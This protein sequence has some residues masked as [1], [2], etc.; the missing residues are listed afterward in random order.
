MSGQDHL[1]A[2]GR[3]PSPGL[4][5]PESEDSDVSAAE[6]DLSAFA[7]PIGLPPAPSKSSLESQQ[8][9]MLRLEDLERHENHNIK[10]HNRLRE[11]RQRMDEKIGRKRAKQD[12]MIN[13][14]MSARGRRDSRI[15]QRRDREDI[16]FQRFYEDLEEEEA[17]SNSHSCLP[18]V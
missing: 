15:K 9:I 5:E 3:Q 8:L 7:L 13:A 17:V 10:K 16:A 18:L 12:E 14:I 11:K 6:D 4:V 2:I 1:P